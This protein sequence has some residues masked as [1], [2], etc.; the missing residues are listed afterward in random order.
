VGLTAAT[1][2]LKAVQYSSLQLWTLIALLSLVTLVARSFFVLL[3][4][5]WQ[6][7]GRVEQALR[8]A[9][10]AALLAIT[11]PE[12]VRQLPTALQHSAPAWA[13]ATDPRLIPALVLATVIR[14][15]R[16]TLWGLLAGTATYL[17]LLRLG[18]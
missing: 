16:H 6:P 14:L 7:R 3:P 11:V 2:G 18:G 17:L 8:Y 1:Q 15:T 12:V 5:R 10:L 4:R 9:P 13:L